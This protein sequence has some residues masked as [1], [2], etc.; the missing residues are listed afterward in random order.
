MEE[1]ATPCL[2]KIKELPFEIIT[3]IVIRLDVCS[4]MNLM[5]TCRHF[6]YPMLASTYIW[7]RIVFDLQYGSLHAIYAALRRFRDSNGLRFLVREI[8]MDN[9]DDSMFS[10][11]VMLVKFPNLRHLSVK[12]R[13]FN[14][15]LEADTKVLQEMLK[16]G[17]LKPGSLR[18]QRLDIY[19]YYMDFEPHLA[20]FQKTLN[21][22]SEDANVV[23]DIR[24]CG[25]Q[26][27]GDMHGL[28]QRM[29]NL[30]LPNNNPDAAVPEDGQLDRP[31]RNDV[32]CQRIINIGMACWACDHV[33]VHC[34]ICQ[35]RC[36][37]CHIKRIPPLANQ[38]QRKL[39]EKQRKLIAQRNRAPEK[40]E[41]LDEFSVFGRI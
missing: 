22:L 23:L 32:G 2:A 9:T 29:G 40:E 35:P 11:I 14:T 28:Q 6:R 16:G 25:Y 26:A 1:A 31:P 30:S 4:T 13:R 20:V 34:W 38:Q 3:D 18:L 33:F 10:P 39:R 27:D 17:T 15:N 36:S 37:G 8:N 41:E 5:D 12:N 19:H 24:K 7:R 21:R